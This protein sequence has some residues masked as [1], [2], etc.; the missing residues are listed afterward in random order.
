MSSGAGGPDRHCPAAADCYPFG[1]L[2]SV[3]GR[4]LWV[5]LTYLP[6]F[7]GSLLFEAMR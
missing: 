4:L 1:W 2:C 6:Q 5:R 7:F 3:T